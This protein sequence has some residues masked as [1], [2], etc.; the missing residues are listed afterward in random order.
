LFLIAAAFLLLA[1]VT[2]R[3]DAS[4]FAYILKYSRIGLSVVAVF[5][6]LGSFR[7]RNI[8]P[9]VRL[10]LL[11]SAYFVAAATWSSAPMM[12]VLN[13]G[14]FLAAFTGGI[15]AASSL[16]SLRD[17]RTGLRTFTVAGIIAGTVILFES[18]IHP[19]DAYIQGRLAVFKM[20]AN[21]LGQATAVFSILTA[22][23]AT[24]ETNRLW[25]MVAVVTCA[26]M[27]WIIIQTGSRGALLMSMLGSG[28]VALGFLRGKTEVMLLLIT[29][30]AM[31]I[32]LL[33]FVTVPD[34]GGRTVY[35]NLVGKESDTR[36]TREIFKDT[37]S[38]FWGRCLDRWRKKPIHGVGWLHSHGRSA[39]TMNMYLQVLVET[40]IIGALMFFVCILAVVRSGWRVFSR[41]HQWSRQLRVLGWLALGCTFGLLVHGVAE[42]STLLGTTSNSLV[43]G[44]AVTLLDRL[45]SLAEPH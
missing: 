35:D 30:A 17:L 27:V 26:I 12:G 43:L 22:A 2:T 7:W 45:P 4:D 1:P 20:N 5:I 25:R 39:T 31:C 33:V 19:D 37:R 8:G 21:S 36:L 40:G 23:L 6:G 13:K 28:L 41:Q 24:L 44:F 11:F 10:L 29:L 32:P 42:S 34:G 15:L 9:T 3:S 18:I 16:S 14:M 38:V